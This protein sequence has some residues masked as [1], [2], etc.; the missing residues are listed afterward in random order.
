M[1]RIK[2]CIV[3]FSYG[4]QVLM[5]SLNNISQISLVGVAYNSK[6]IQNIKKKYKNIKFSKNYEKLIN[7]LKPNFVL[8]S[9]PNN[10]QVNVINFLIKKKR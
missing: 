10:V 9:T 7:D 6:N 1:N 5:Q 2:V 8:I 4:Q 3:G